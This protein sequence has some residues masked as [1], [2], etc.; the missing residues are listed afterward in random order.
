MNKEQQVLL[1]LLKE[2]DKICTENKIE[3]YLAPRLAVHA[4]YGEGMPQS[5]LAGGILMKLA[6]MERFRQAFSQEKPED[7]ALESMCEYER[8]PGFFLRYEDKNS[9]C[10]RMDEG[11][12]YQ[13]PGIGID[14][15]PLRG[16]ES[17]RLT[18]LWNRC[19]ELGWIQFGDG[20]SQEFTWKEKLCKIPVGILMAG[21]RARLGKYLYQKFY[22]SQ[23]EC[24]E[25]N[26]VV[27]LKGATLYYPKKI[28]A[29]T[30]RVTLEGVSLSVPDQVDEYLK[31]WFGK[32]FLNKLTEPYVPSMTVITS[33]NIRSEDFLAK[34][35]QEVKSLVKER[36]DQYDKDR[37]GRKSR[38][39]LDWSWNY[40]KMKGE[41]V[42]LESVY[43]RKKAYLQNLLENKDYPRLAEE[44]K[45]Y[46][47]IMKKYLG[48]GE[49]YEPDQEI[50]QIYL[51]VL[52]ATG[53]NGLLN[54]IKKA[55]GQTA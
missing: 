10:F 17:S 11:R 41:G 49:V 14:I 4:V 34:Y 46:D 24:R 48:A 12:N 23:K 51:K 55:S 18:H 38:E 35:S 13:Y 54:K 21:G 50:F 44:M 5:P 3:Y 8:F 9:L 2:V 43:A 36:K 7:R 22:E 15:Y 27:R 31:V 1:S 40:V 33:T 32:G 26:Y 29:K 20:R 45:D 25:K 42:N 6:D 28:F 30:R 53:K 37:K 16:K 52:A 19:L 39:Y 47:R